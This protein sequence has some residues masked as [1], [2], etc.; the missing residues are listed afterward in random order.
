MEKIGIITDDVLTAL[1]IECQTIWE[2]DY[3]CK[4]EGFGRSWLGSE[5]LEFDRHKQ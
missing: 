5:T 3:E 1:V 2:N 4:Y